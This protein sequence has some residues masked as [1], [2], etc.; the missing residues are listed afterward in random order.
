MAQGKT[1]VFDWSARLSFGDIDRVPTERT[2]PD[3]GPYATELRG[4][5]G[6]GFESPPNRSRPRETPPAGANHANNTD[7]PRGDFV[8]IKLNLCTGRAIIRFR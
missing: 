3:P 7:K 1:S 2:I 8:H 5:L 4:P 6:S